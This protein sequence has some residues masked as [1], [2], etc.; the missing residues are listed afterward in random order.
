MI[1]CSEFLGRLGNELFQYASLYGIAM[2]NKEML[3][4]PNWKYAKYFEGFFPTTEEPIHAYKTFNEQRFEYHADYISD[5]IADERTINP[6]GII[7]FKGYFQSYKYW[8]HCENEVRKMLA[9]K[10]SFIYDVLLRSQK[11]GFNFIGGRKNVAVC[12]R[13]GDYVGNPGYHQIDI[14]YYVNEIYKRLDDDVRFC[15]FSDDI[16]YCKVHFECLGDKAFFS[17]GMTDIEDLCLISQCDSHI[18]GNSTFHWWG[19]YLS[20]SKDVVRPGKY[21]SGHLSKHDTKDFWP[22]EWRIPVNSELFPLV[23]SVKPSMFTIF[24]EDSSD[25]YKNMHLFMKMSSRTYPSTIVQVTESVMHRTKLINWFVKEMNHESD[26]MVHVDI[27]V[28]IP[29]M[30]LVMAV[31]MVAD[32]KSDF[33]YPYGGNFVK[34]NRSSWYK[35]LFETLDV[36][37][38]APAVTPMKKQSVGGALV[39]S[40]KAFIEAGMENENFIS[41]GPEDKERFFRFLT[42]GYRVDRIPGNAYHMN[43]FIGSDSST[44]NK[45]YVNNVNEYNKV[46][47][48]TKEQLVEYVKTWE[49]VPKDK[50]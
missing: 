41:Y 10:S 14:N 16:E 31:K 1:T 25:R 18:I 49:W 46:R 44:A 48:M 27:D 34:V 15:F 47:S 3:T 36:G 28:T 23:Y 13:R 32:G 22:E 26:V 40:R 33:V 38:L 7:N 45:H 37:I 19:A 30:Q 4:I 20:G 17:E 42:L 6:S 9:F 21:F 39:F 24:K 2:Q 50:N 5:V 35:R 43:H 11:N 12:I 29:P 8:K